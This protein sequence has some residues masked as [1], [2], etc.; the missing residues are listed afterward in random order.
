MEIAEGET[1]EATTKTKEHQ[2]TTIKKGIM[3]KN[4]GLRQTPKSSS[5]SQ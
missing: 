5:M 4:Q 2:E 3:R 1:H